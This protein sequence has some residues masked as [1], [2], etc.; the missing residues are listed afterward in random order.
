MGILI[1]QLHDDL[2]NFY[3][4][5]TVDAIVGGSITSAG[6]PDEI[7]LS[8]YITEDFKTE[9]DS[10]IFKMLVYSDSFTYIALEVS[11]NPNYGLKK[12]GNNIIA[13]GMPVAYFPERPIVMKTLTDDP[14]SKCEVVWDTDG[15]VRLVVV[16]N[17]TV[18]ISNN[19]VSTTSVVNVNAISA[20]VLA[21]DGVRVKNQG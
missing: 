11:K 12:G 21:I 10:G 17:E 1:K 20:I 15:L 9:D 19:V 3:P 13:R 18:T 16:P 2:A 8:S 4:I 6:L 5:S 7:D 14:D